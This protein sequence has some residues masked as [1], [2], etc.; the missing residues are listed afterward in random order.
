[1]VAHDDGRLELLLSLSG[2]LPVPVRGTVY[3]CPLA[4]WLPLEFPSSAPIVLVLPTA[5]LKVRVGPN[6]DSAGRVTGG[7]ID[8]WQRKAEVSH[9]EWVA[10]LGRTSVARGAG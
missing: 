9:P 10:T 4:F 3:N 7:Y 2:V 8:G 1:M 5:T 6:V